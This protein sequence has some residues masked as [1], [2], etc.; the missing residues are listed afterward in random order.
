MSNFNELFYIFKRVSTSPIPLTV[1]SVLTVEYYVEDEKFIEV[2]SNFMDKIFEKEGITTNSQFC[3]VI[4]DEKNEYVSVFESYLTLSKEKREMKRK[5]YAIDMTLNNFI[6]NINSTEREIL[7]KFYYATNGPNWKRNDNWL[8]DKPL[9]EWFGIKVHEGSDE[10]FIIKVLDLYN[11]KLEGVLPKEIGKLTNLQWLYLYNNKLEGEIPKEIGKLNNLQRLSL[12]I[13]KLE[14]EIPKEIG[15]LTN[16]QKL[17]L[18]N[19]KLEGEIPKEI[20]ELK[21][22]KK[23]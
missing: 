15:K 12:S 1:R 21:C 11:N 6:R 8:S 19:N 23:I 9:K 10:K 16:L 3:E 20:Q 18:S 5:L 4:Q 22:Y 2:L 14:G 17:F 13:N 7:E